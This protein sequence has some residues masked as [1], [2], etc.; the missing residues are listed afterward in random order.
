ME[1]DIATAWHQ[2]SI[3]VTRFDFDL[4]TYCNAINH[5]TDR[6]TGGTDRDTGGTDRDTGGT[7]RDT[8]SI[9]QIYML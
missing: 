2:S 8:F 5:G 3:T 6:D 9:L 7:D 4:H 1:Y